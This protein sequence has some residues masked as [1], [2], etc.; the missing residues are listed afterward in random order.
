MLLATWEDAV[1]PLMQQALLTPLLGHSRWFIEEEFVS[2][3]RGRSS[4]WHNLCSNT[5]SWAPQTSP[6][7]FAPDLHVLASQ[8]GAQSQFKVPRF[9]QAPPAQA[10][11]FGLRKV[12]TCSKGFNSLQCWPWALNRTYAGKYQFEMWEGTQKSLPEDERMEFNHV[13]YKNLGD[14]PTTGWNSLDI[15]DASARALWEWLTPTCPA[16]KRPASTQN[17]GRIPRTHQDGKKPL[18]TSKPGL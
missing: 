17:V 5:S 2:Q 15:S 6:W 11:R 3:T 14:I 13:I 7:Y 9:Q 10:K 1:Y 8:A 12:R 4:D 16:G 18:T